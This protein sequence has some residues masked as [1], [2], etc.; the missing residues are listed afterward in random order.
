MLESLVNP[1][2][3]EKGPWKMF[4]I[5]LLYASLSLLLVQLFFSSDPVLSKFSGILVVTFC[6]MFSIPFMYYMIK[7]E[8]KEDEEVVSFIGVWKIHKDAIYGFLWLFLGFVIAFSFWFLVL[9]DT[10]LLNAQIQTYCMINSPGSL[11]S[12]VSQ[13]IS[14]NAITPTG[15]AANVG[16]LLSIIENNV[17]VMIFT[18]IFSLIFGAGAIFV[19]AWNATVI[20][21][22]IG[23]FTKYKISGIPLGLARYMIHGLP[24]IGAYFITA[25]AG[26]ILGVGI[27]RNGIKSK[28]FLR[29]LENVIILLFVSILVLI[30]AALIEVY[31]TPILF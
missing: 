27:M 9:Q 23:I 6:V 1:K 16:R 19:L 8:E 10:N 17:Y 21:S 20:A 26:G 11:D 22:A 30:V 4:F 13:Y 3:V 25:L 5:G 2:R 28:K 12:C 14:G 29:V 15:G 24:E 7:Q 31:F 18:L